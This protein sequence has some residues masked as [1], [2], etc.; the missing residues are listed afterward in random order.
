MMIN[1]SHI[2]HMF[3]VAT[4]NYLH[5][6][7]S[8]LPVV[9]TMGQHT[10]DQQEKFHLILGLLTS[11]GRKREKGKKWGFYVFFNEDCYVFNCFAGVSNVTAA[12]CGA[13]FL[14][15]QLQ[16]G[17][18]VPSTLPG[19]H[20]FLCPKP[21]KYLFWDTLH[22]TEHT[23]KVLFKEFWDGNSTIT[24]PINFKTLASL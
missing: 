15:A 1:M 5:F 8:F 3:S 18:P 19:V 17:R 20:A 12:C 7:W 24:Y 22:P 4:S 6:G 16:C 14:N 11:W 21:S 10:N 13:G 23:V 9:R 2:N